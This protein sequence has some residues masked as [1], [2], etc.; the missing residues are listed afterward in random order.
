[1]IPKIEIPI[2]GIKPI[3]LDIVTAQTVLPPSVPIN[4]PIGFP[5]IEMPCVKA[6]KSFENGLPIDGSDTN[7]DTT[8][9]GRVPSIQ[10]L[11]NAFD[12]RNRVLQRLATGHKRLKKVSHIK[13]S[14]NTQNGSICI[15]NPICVTDC[16]GI[17]NG[18]AK[19]D[20][21]GVCRDPECSSGPPEPYYTEANN[22]CSDNEYP[23]NLNWN[24]SC[25]DCYN[26]IN[27]VGLIRKRALLIHFG[28]ARAL[29][30][31]SL[32]EIKSVE[33]VEEK[34]AKKIYNFF[35]E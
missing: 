10:S 18:I 19:Y 3:N 11:V 7:I 33:G 6:R 24:S 30:S 5:I 27:G 23:T 1:M 13:V 16:F 25:I 22:P 35:H 17:P 29:E 26:Q 8:A 9:W 20:E 34:V 21:C 28:S 12:N 15:E 2:V 31:A 14:V 32:D 4:V